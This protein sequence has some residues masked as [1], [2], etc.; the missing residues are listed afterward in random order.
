MS[1]CEALVAATLSRLLAPKCKAF[2]GV[3]LLSGAAFL[4]S[5]VLIRVGCDLGAS[6]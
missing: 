4:W 5:I 6:I 1:D 3:V 2:L